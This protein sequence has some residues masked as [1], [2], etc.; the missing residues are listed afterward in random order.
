MPI[1]HPHRHQHRHQH[2]EKQE[3]LHQRSA[4]KKHKPTERLF[5]AIEKEL[6]YK[7]NRI[8]SLELEAEE[9]NEQFNA[10]A[11]E[12]TRLREESASIKRLNKQL[13]LRLQDISNKDR[14]DFHNI[15]LLSASKLRDMVKKYAAAHKHEKNRRKQLDIA[16]QKMLTKLKAAKEAHA[17]FMKIQKAAQEQAEYIRNL[18][19][20]QRE[21]NQYKDTIVSQEQ[22]I[23][24]LEEMLSW[25][26]QTIKSLQQ[27][28]DSGNVVSNRERELENEVISLQQENDELRKQI[29]SIRADRMR[30]NLA[31]VDKLKDELRQANYRNDGLQEQLKTDAGHFGK[32][33]GELKMQIKKM[34]HDESDDIEL[35]EDMFSGLSDIT[36]AELSHISDLLNSVDTNLTGKDDD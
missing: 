19:K 16:S 32:Q 11:N 10:I 22:V 4:I 26:H 25:A 29:Q 3:I 6:T 21:M 33:I 13:T 5:I 9:K 31:N 18:Q 27:K 1:S 28:M 36:T 12:I 2:E 35:D 7:Q 23:E 34:R 30:E 17:K 15:D 8:E 14:E 20:K 24:K